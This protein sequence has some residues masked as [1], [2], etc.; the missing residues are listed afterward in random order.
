MLKLIRMSALWM[1]NTLNDVLLKLNLF[2]NWPQNWQNEPNLLGVFILETLGEGENQ[3]NNLVSFFMYIQFYFYFNLFL[4]FNGPLYIEVLIYE[5]R[6]HTFIICERQ[7]YTMNIKIRIVQAS[8]NTFMTNLVKYGPLVNSM[9]H[10]STWI[11]KA[12]KRG[13]Y[14]DRHVNLSKK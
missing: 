13:F 11:C 10:L 7:D 3:F 1:H 5:Q 9:S 4:G 12:R 6:R 8:C 2:I 14:L